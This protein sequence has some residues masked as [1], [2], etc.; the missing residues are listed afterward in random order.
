MKKENKRMSRITIGL[1]GIM[2][3][4]L[5]ISGIVLTASSVL[6]ILDYIYFFSYVKLAITIMKYIPQVNLIILLAYLLMNI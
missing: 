6:T 5:T 1:L 4:F 3:S 2:I